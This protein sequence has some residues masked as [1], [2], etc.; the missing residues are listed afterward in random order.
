MSD[1]AHNAFT[2]VI[3]ILA[4]PFHADESIDFD[5]WKRTIAFMLS[6]KV[7]GLTVAGVLGE[8]DRLTD[9]ERIALIETAARAIDGRVPLIAGVSHRGTRAVLSLA[10]AARDAGAT[11]I[12]LAP[13]KEATPNEERIYETYARLAATASMPIIVQDHP[14]STETHMSVALIARIANEL[15]AVRAIKAEAVPVGP[16]IAAIRAQ[17]ARPVSILAGLGALY[18]PFDLAAGAD[19]FNTGFAFPEVLQ[20]MIA[21]QRAGDQPMLDAHFAR[22]AALIVLEQQPGVAIRKE[23]LKRRGLFATSTVRHP[24]APLSAHAAAT[25]TALIERTF[26]RMDIARPIQP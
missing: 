11:A 2:G 7:D 25:L 4:T 12:M 19:G 8:A 3:P 26:G 17:L 1:F 15:T 14:A 22:F 16:K 9:R 6:L 24:G 18:A 5:S 20:A 10:E 13:Q 23:V 21:A